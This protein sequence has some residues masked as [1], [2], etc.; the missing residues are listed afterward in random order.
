MA[1]DGRSENYLYSGDIVKEGKSVIFS[2]MYPNLT[3]DFG[4]KIGTIEN[5]EVYETT[6]I[7][8]H[9]HRY[10]PDACLLM[11]WNNTVPIFAKIEKL[12]VY[13]YIKFAVCSDFDMQTF[14]WVSNS[15]KIAEGE[16][17]TLVLLT[18]LKNKWP[19]PIYE[20]SETKLVCNH[21]SHFGQG[22]F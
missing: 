21:Y 22:F 12:F 11:K 17:K 9:S 3:D 4:N 14:Q 6:E 8:M 18:E 2:E 10:R 20:Y 16:G 7:I 15:F 5:Y 1:S 19:L 13:D